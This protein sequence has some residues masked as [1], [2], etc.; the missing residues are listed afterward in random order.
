VEYLFTSRPENPVAFRMAMNPFFHK[1]SC[2]KCYRFQAATTVGNANSIGNKQQIKV[3]F[4]IANWQFGY[5][6][7]RSSACN[8]FAMRELSTSFSFTWISDGYWFTG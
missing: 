4:Q 1:S 8:S 5:L 7:Y 3:L 2:L 6:P